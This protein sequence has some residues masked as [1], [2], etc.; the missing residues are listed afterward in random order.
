MHASTRTERAADGGQY[1][2]LVGLGDGE[3][4]WQ[5]GTASYEEV[6]LGP[7][8]EISGEDWEGSGMLNKPGGSTK[9]MPMERR[10]SVDGQD[11]A[12]EWNDDA[13]WS[14][15]MILRGK[16]AHAQDS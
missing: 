1:I 5:A 7:N 12:R 3:P 14:H 15:S 6:S 10:A 13:D 2:P 8:F 4:L 11:E 9:S 16:P